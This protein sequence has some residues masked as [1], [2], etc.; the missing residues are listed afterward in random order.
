MPKPPAPSQLSKTW[1]K[2]YTAVPLSS[3]V[4][5]DWSSEEDWDS[6]KQKE[7]ERLDKI[8]KEQQRKIAEDRR[9]KR[10]EE[11][12]QLCL[13]NPI[14]TKPNSPLIDPLVPV[15]E[16]KEENKRQE[17]NKDHTMTITS[18][19]PYRLSVMKNKSNLSKQFS[20]RSGPQKKRKTQ[21]KQKETRQWKIEETL[22]S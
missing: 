11:N 17:E 6:A 13:P 5:S 14:N 7:R 3:S 16:E 9:K 2:P 18:H 1:A 22:M 10:E 8:I 12:A 19:V 21:T 20:T 15:P 4:H